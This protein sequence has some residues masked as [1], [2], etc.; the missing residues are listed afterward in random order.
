[1]PVL[2]IAA[3]LLALAAPALA[4]DDAPLD[5]K[6]MTWRGVQLGPEQVYEGDFTTDYQT[7]VLRTGGETVW[8]S[9]WADRPGDNGGITR[10]YHIRFVG[11]HTLEPGKFGG[12]GAYAHTILLT[13]LLSARVLIGEP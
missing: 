8:L 2:A 10:R 7:S 4:Q 6:P 11:R 3:A 1:M 13:R 9:G 5:A 12:L